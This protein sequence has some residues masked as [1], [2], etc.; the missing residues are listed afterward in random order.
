MA[1]QC[2]RDAIALPALGEDV[3]VTA[4]AGRTA[5][6]VRHAADPATVRTIAVA[7]DVDRL[8]GTRRRSGKSISQYFF[9]FERRAMASH[10]MRSTLGAGS[11]NIA[12][13]LCPRVARK[14]QAQERRRCH[15]PYHA[16]R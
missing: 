4:H 2:G 14:L 8:G 5:I 10:M 9:D 15:T 6:T 1:R 3:G 13:Q 7:V 12:S 16:A 11:A